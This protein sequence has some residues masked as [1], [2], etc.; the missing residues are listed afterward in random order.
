MPF[1]ILVVMIILSDPYIAQVSGARN[2]KGEAYV[3]GCVGLGAV[4]YWLRA[5]RSGAWFSP[6]ER[7]EVTSCF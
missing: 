5:L 2:R 1:E 6:L 4:G 3:E 7:M